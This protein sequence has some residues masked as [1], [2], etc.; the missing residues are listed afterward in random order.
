MASA[1]PNEC[2]DVPMVKPSFFGYFRSISLA[3]STEVPKAP[4][5]AFAPRKIS[6]TF[7]CQSR[8]VDVPA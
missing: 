1:P 3:Y 7:V 5:G 6:P 4:S 8:L 2:P